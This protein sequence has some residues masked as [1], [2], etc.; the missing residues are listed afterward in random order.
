[1]GRKVKKTLTRQT[2]AM[3]TTSHCPSFS[4]ASSNRSKSM[5]FCS[6]FPLACAGN[7]SA[8]VTRRPASQTRVNVVDAMSSRRR[9]RPVW[10]VAPKMSA[11]C[12]C[13][14][15]IVW[16]TMSCNLTMRPTGHRALTLLELNCPSEPGMSR[17]YQAVSHDFGTSFHGYVLLVITEYGNVWVFVLNVGIV[18][19]YSMNANRF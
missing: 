8:G 14:S 3:N 2:H 5:T 19:S 18:A 1:M 10:P 9:W 13:G 7:S 15:D 4:P 11:D 17:L 12:G 16:F 6:I